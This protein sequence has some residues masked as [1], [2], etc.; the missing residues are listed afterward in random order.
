MNPTQLAAT[1]PTEQLLNPLKTAALQTIALGARRPAATTPTAAPK[2]KKSPIHRIIQGE[3]L[4]VMKKIP[5]QAI[6]F[7]CADLPYNISGKGGLTMRGNAIVRADFGDWDKFPSEQVYLDF[8]FQVCA[9]YRRILK[10]NASLMLFFWYRHAGWIG[11]ELERR[12]LFTF[13][14]PVIWA[15]DNPMP[16]IKKTSFRSCYEMGLWLTNDGGHFRKPRTFNFL[17]QNHMTNVMHYL[18]G[19]DGNKRTGHPTEKPELLTQRI[20]EVFSNPGDIVLDSFAW[21]GT[22]GCAAIKAGRNA[23]SIEREAKYIAMIHERQAAIDRQQGN[24]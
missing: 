6:H 22:T 16:S 15:K 11:H 21:G 12:W 20:I 10:P 18:I 19:R 3:C 2:P 9:E 13:R 4:E 14:M 23:I 5:D 24:A 8:V 7:I 17:A 1:S